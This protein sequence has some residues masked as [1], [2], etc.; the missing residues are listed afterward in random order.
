M[1]TE[2]EIYW[3]TRM[4]YIQT[5]LFVLGGIITGLAGISFVVSAICC[6]RNVIHGD[7]DAKRMMVVSK[8]T[9]LTSI[10]CG[11]VFGSILLSACFVPSTKEMC[12]IKIIPKI[13]NNEEV[14]ELPNKVVELANEWL[15]ELKPKNEFREE[16]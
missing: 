6:A 7:D 5:A 15:E 9:L 3:I 13:V 1:I 16:E 10:V 2:S 4:D 11:L 12:A 8:K 14:Q